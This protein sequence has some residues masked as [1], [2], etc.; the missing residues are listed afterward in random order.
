M[1]KIKVALIRGAFLNPNE[2]A[3]YEPL[4]N[5]LKLTSFSSQ[6]PLGT[7]N[8][9]RNC[10]LYSLYDYNSQLL[11]YLINRTLG[12]SHYLHN[13]GNYLKSFDIIDTADPYYYYSYQAARFKK[14]KPS[15]KLVS[16]YCE[17]IPFNNEK[18]WAKKRLKKYTMEQTDLFIVHTNLSYNCLIK[19]GVNPDL[20]KI[21]RLGVNLTKFRPVKKLNNTILF[22]GR[23]VPEKGV[24]ELY[25]AYKQLLKKYPKYSL[26]LVGDGMLKNK[27]TKDIYKNN[28][29]QK[30]KIT[31]ISYH[32]IASVYKQANIF[33]LPSYKTKTWEEQYG[34][35]L[36]EAMASGLSIAASSCGAIP[37]VLDKSGLIFKQN[38]TNDLYLALDRILG[39]T[40][41]QNKLSN[42]AR[43]RAEIHFN[44]FD[45]A[46]RINS[47]YDKLN[48]CNSF[49]QRKR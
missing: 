43:A 33:V 39:N 22:V 41:L 11:R 5:K 15:L 40:T 48:S 12:D 44:H 9:I 46:D 16:T 21:N 20:I 18:T 31:N 14:L 32:N 42:Q 17:T 27:L 13:L 24:W 26:A 19:E 7:N 36:I 47:I 35:A 1:N 3:N 34:M 37:E 28:L 29:E 38:N 45:F 8:K 2:L 30:V 25:S 6:K 49:A 23:L 10:K 4:I